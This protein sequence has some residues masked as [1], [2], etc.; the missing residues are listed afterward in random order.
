MG[1]WVTGWSEVGLRLCWLR[2]APRWFD[3]KRVN[4]NRKPVEP[5]LTE[6]MKHKESLPLIYKG[7][8]KCL[9]NVDLVVSIHTQAMLNIG[10]GRGG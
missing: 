1:R 8:N 7:D 2:M 9:I 3:R 10:R 6:P 5:V 4:G